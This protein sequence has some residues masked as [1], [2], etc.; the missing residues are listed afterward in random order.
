M[1][2]RNLQN[3]EYPMALA[4]AWRVFQRFEAP[5]YPAE[6]VAHFQKTLQDRSF[7]DGLQVYGA[8]NDQHLIGMIATRNEGRHIAL[9]FVEETYHRRGIGRALFLTVCEDVPDDHLTVNSSPFAVPV[10]QKLGFTATD[11][12]QLK[13]GIRY[14]PMV[15]H[16]PKA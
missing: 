9:F 13:D 11:A 8:Y 4:L 12:E 15:F 10:Y 2:V 6:G 1:I 14:T 7:T 3:Q 16:L 5:E